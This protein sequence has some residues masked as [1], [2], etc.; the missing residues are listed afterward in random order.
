MSNTT[1]VKDI[2]FDEIPTT[3]K[4]INFKELFLSLQEGDNILRFIDLNGKK[5]GTHWVKDVSGKQRS[6]KCPVSGCPCCLHK[7]EK[8]NPEPVPTQFKIFMKVVDKLG[9]IRVLEFGSQIHNQ[10]KNINKEL[11]EEDSNATLT[12]RDVNIVKGIKGSNPLYTVKLVKQN[13]KLS[14]QEQLRIQAIEEAVVKDT[15]NLSEIIVPWTVKRV[16]EQIYG[17]VESTDSATTPNSNTV[18]VAPA[19]VVASVNTPV[20]TSAPKVV[21]PASEDDLSIFDK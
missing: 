20:V 8:G 11:K 9:V 15:I 1:V 4:K 7:D 5:I 21:V 6:V 2:N 12:Q 13:P 16:N 10:L 17:I 14:F 3:Q 19:P 18:S